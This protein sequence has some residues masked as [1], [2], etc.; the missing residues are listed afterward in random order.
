MSR[1]R[2]TLKDTVCKAID[3]R[4]QEICEIGEN[5]WRNAELGFKEFRTSNLIAKRFE[6]LGLAFEKNIA[7]T[8][9][10]ARIEGKGKGPTIAVI[11]E[12]DALVCYDHPEANPSTGAVHACGHNAQAAG[13]LGVAMGLVDSGIMKELPGNIV[14]MAVPAEEYVE[15]EYRLSLRM[16]GEI[17]FLGG[18]QEFIRLG[19]FDDVDLAVTDHSRGEMPER[20]AEVGGSL[21]GFIGK[22]VQYRGRESHAGGRPEMGVNALNA[23]L[24]GLMGIHVQRETFKDD[25]HIRVHPIITKGGEMVNIIPADIRIE[26]Y[27]RGKTMEAIADANVK[28]NRAL[29]AGADA[30]GATVAIEDIPGYLPTEFDPMM[31]G[32]FIENLS[33]LIGRENVSLD[34]THRTGSSDIGDVSC[35]VPTTS[36]HV[37]GV[38]GGSHSKDFKIVDPEMEYVVPAKAM[39][40]LVVD[41]LF[42]EG[43]TAKNVI[44][45]F[46]PKVFKK[47]YVDLWRRV[48]GSGSAPHGLGISRRE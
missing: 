30:V 3:D 32:L 26:T 19:K 1:D 37:G 15:I 39:A 24:L 4:R 21:N 34:V 6:S 42:D 20:K 36:V 41:L 48:M 2:N 17:E 13:M 9:V 27:V 35:I 5:I 45:A 23:A 38:S 7:V 16:K 31:N 10:I 14:F 46:K 18:K 12:M 8:G 47:D 11:G 44:S 33:A 40:M 22:M 28:V 25:D 43:V 29:K